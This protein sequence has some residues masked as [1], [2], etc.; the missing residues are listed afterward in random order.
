MLNMPNLITLIR[1]ALIPCFVAL[2]LRYRESGG[3]A[4]R[5]WERA[6]MG[7]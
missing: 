5:W 1:I 2:L 3:E 4:L 7:T 6:R